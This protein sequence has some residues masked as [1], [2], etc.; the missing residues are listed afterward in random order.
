MFWHDWLLARLL[1]CFCLLTWGYNLAI[2]IHKFNTKPD[3]CVKYKTLGSIIYKQ[4]G[5]RK[6]KVVCR[7]IKNL[8]TKN[9]R[10]GRGD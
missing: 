3:I 10:S 6:I 8:G 7:E 4:R 5:A 1:C 9:N 2:K